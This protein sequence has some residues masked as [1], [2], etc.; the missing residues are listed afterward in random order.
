M[1]LSL[2]LLLTCTGKV[3]TCTLCKIIKK[4]VTFEL[5]IQTAFPLFNIN[6][7]NNNNIIVIFFVVV[8]GSV[9]YEES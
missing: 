2:L 3:C 7:N 4:D 8:I 6:N 5:F 9:Q 1:I